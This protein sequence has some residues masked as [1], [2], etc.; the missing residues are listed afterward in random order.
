MNRAM[1]REYSGK[2]LALGPRSKGLAFPAAFERLRLISPG[3]EIEESGLS[4]TGIKAEHGPL[5]I[6]LGP[7]RK[8]LYPG[9][10]ERVG[11][12]TIGFDIGFDGLRVV[13]LGDTLL[14]LDDWSEVREPDLL[15]LPIGGKDVRNTMDEEEALQAVKTIRPRHVIPTHYNCPAFFTS[16]Y[17]P[18]DAMRFKREVERI[19][20]ACHVMDRGDE[21]SI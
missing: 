11:W 8:T 9:P 21:T 15:M 5:A 4:V 13:N 6:K 14:R 2:Q 10:D 18:A 7:I 1:V 12:G 16:R 20:P 3:E 17:N 19:G